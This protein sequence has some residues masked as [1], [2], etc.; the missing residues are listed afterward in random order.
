MESVNKINYKRFYFETPYDSQ[1]WYYYSTSTTN[2]K[3]F[4]EKGIT[5][6]IR[7]LE[8]QIPWFCLALN[9]NLETKYLWQFITMLIKLTFL[10][11]ADRVKSVNSF[12]YKILNI[13]A[14]TLKLEI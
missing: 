9:L 7:L 10:L 8:S 3:N 2:Y 4:K 11:V 6:P 12:N 1:T 5:L 13:Q 14:M